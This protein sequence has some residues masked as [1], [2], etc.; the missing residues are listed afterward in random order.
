MASNFAIGINQPIF[1]TDVSK[2]ALLEDSI[3]ILD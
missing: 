3:L 1:I 2:S